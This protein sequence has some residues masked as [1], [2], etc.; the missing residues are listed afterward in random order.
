MAREFA[1]VL[2][3]VWND[4]DGWK[5]LNSVDHDVFVALLTSPDLSWCGVAPLLP[6]RLVEFSADLTLR[7]V[8]NSIRALEAARLVVTDDKTGEILVRS[9]VRHDGVMAKPNI[10]KA[11]LRAR[12]KV[13]SESIRDAI[14]AEL[15]RIHDQSPTL[16]GW[17]TMVTI[18]PD[19]MPN[20]SANSSLNGSANGSVN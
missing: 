18:E 12:S 4:D 1:R 14:D 6:Q 2:L 15:N 19:I 10:V 17:T 8:H 16:A 11:M 3:S 9:Y 7:K 13:R 20:G 5:M